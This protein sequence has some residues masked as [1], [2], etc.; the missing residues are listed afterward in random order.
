[1]ALPV[2]L[3]IVLRTAA[4]WGTTVIAMRQLGGGESFA[5]GD[6]KEASLPKPDGSP[7]PD[8]PVRA[9]GTGWELD[10]R[11]ATGGVVFL[12]GRQENAADLGRGGA[13]VPIV[14]GD[15]GVVQYGPTFSVFFQFANVPPPIRDRIRAEW[16]LIFAF[17]FSLVA[18]SPWSGPSP[19][20][21]PFRS[22]SS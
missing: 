14:A 12:R 11:G 13:P 8:V 7:M 3:P 10:A 19:H 2:A 4:V 9:V 22:P 16:G 21:R 15:F 1:M 6:F 18:I 17:I 20:L 5:F